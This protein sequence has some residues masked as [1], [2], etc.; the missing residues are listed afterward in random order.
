G[1]HDAEHEDRHP[2][3]LPVLLLLRI[4]AH[5]AVE[6]AL[7]PAEPREPTLCGEPAVRVDARQVDA[8]GVAERDQDERVDDD[9][10]DALRR[11]LEPFT[12]EERVDEV[13]EDRDG[14]RKSERV[15]GRHQTRPIAWRSA[16]MHAK[17][18]SAIAI[19]ARSNISGALRACPT[20]LSR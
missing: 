18:A 13:R 8:E 12:A 7:D 19:A 11:H 9:L 15:R 17:H 3:A 4:R 1:E 5:E 6:A 10:R 20:W 14:D 2:V 16:N